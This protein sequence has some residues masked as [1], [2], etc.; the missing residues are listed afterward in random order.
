MSPSNSWLRGS[1]VVASLLV[2]LPTHADDRRIP[3]GWTRSARTDAPKPRFA[4]ELLS[5]LDQREA[6]F[7]QSIGGASRTI[8]VTA[9]P[10]V[11]VAPEDAAIPPALPP[12]EAGEIVVLKGNRVS[13]QGFEA[14]I[15]RIGKDIDAVGRQSE[16]GLAKM[17]GAGT[18]L[19]GLA[20]VHYE[21][22]RRIDPK[23]TLELIIADGFL[24]RASCKAAITKRIRV[25]PKTFGESALFGFRTRCD[26]CTPGKRT[27]LHLLTPQNNSLALDKPLPFQR[28]TLA[29]DPGTSGSVNINTSFKTPGGHGGLGTGWFS[30]TG[31]NAFTMPDWEGFAPRPCTEKTWCSAAVR[32]D[33]SRG[34]VETNATLVMSALR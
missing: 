29:L 9:L 5:M 12:G 22:V 32:I 8:D 20:Q 2:A 3:S 23:G 33:V 34:A 7:V 31:A 17:C 1:L 26:A 10:E 21:A 24:D 15:L 14:A 16:G 28:L 18:N 30:G 13:L 6:P 19:S 27:M 25:V 11:E 4:V